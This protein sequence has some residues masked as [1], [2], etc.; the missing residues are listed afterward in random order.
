MVYK[1]IKVDQ[2]FI[3]NDGGGLKERVRTDNIIKIYHI[4][5]NNY[6]FIFL[7]FFNNS[8]GL[9]ADLGFPPLLLRHTHTNTHH[10]YYGI[11]TQT[12]YSDQSDCKTRVQLFVFIVC[13]FSK[14]EIEKMRRVVKLIQAYH[15]K[16]GLRVPQEQGKV[17]VPDKVL[18]ALSEFTG[19]HLEPKDL[20]KGGDAETVSWRKSMVLGGEAPTMVSMGAG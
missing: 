14:R 18:K 7:S 6:L 5:N 9:V 8:D 16:R 19:E 2:N 20:L 11:H 13:K 12:H 3:I 1:N 10:C 4:K 15:L 17:R